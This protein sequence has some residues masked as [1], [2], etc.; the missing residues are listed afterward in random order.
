MLNK[1]HFIPTVYVYKRQKEQAILWKNTQ[2]TKTK[3]GNKQTRLQTKYSG[4]KCK[5]EIH[6]SLYSN[7]LSSAE[8]C[9]T[10]SVWNQDQNTPGRSMLE[11]K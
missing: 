4:K 5:E 1:Y 2:L 10:G 7:K 9:T 3:K 8:E 11:I 6:I